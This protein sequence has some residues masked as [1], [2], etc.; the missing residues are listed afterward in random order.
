MR[1]QN[2]YKW[3]YKKSCYFYFSSLITYVSHERASNACEGANLWRNFCK[4]N[5]KHNLRTKLFPAQH[6]LMDKLQYYTVFTICTISSLA[7]TFPHIILAIFNEKSLTN[8]DARYW[9]EIRS[10]SL[11]TKRTSMS[12]SSCA[13]SIWSWKMMGKLPN[14]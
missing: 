2:L 7:L 12:L 4:D 8:I 3:R 13:S 10:R 9:I 5:E 11:N 14:F 6:I 1:N